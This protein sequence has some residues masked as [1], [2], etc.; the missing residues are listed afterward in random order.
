MEYLLTAK[1]FLLSA[2]S[3]WFVW[4]MAF[5]V[6]AGVSA[7]FMYHWKPHFAHS[8]T[9]KRTALVYFI[10]GAVILLSAALIIIFF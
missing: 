4:V 1:D 3:L 7:I 8:T 9:I 2:G 10:G 5:L 6:F